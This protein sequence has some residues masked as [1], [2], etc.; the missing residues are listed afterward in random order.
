MQLIM[1]KRSKEKMRDRKTKRGI[2]NQ[3]AIKK[4]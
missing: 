2:P 1:E 4:N 3:K